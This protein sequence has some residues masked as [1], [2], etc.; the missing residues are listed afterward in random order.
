MS[1]IPTTSTVSN[2][3][4]STESTAE[5]LDEPQKKRVKLYL[6]SFRSTSGNGSNTS[7]SATSIKAISDSDKLENRLGGI[8]CCT[9][10]LDLPKAAVYQ[11]SDFKILLSICK[12]K[13]DFKKFF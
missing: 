7:G 1:D 11:V 8:L 3:L 9:V 6:A 2:M 12:I 4:M 10:C 5:N 13:I